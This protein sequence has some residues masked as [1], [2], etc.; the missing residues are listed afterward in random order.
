MGYVNDLPESAPKSLCLVPAI[1]LLQS[2]DGVSRTENLD[3]L[4]VQK[5]KQR[6]KNFPGGLFN[7]L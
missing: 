6:Y 1:W 7:K 3:A 5:F 4:V 2:S